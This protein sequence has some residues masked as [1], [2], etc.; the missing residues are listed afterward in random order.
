[1]EQLANEMMKRIH[2]LTSENKALRMTNLDKDKEISKLKQRIENGYDSNDDNIFCDYCS[3]LATRK[4]DGDDLC[5]KC[6]LREK[7]KD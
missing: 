4:H 3:T 2:E 7:Y 1:M 6:Y 5:D